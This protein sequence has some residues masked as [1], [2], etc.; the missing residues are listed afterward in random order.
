VYQFIGLSYEIRKFQSSDYFND[1][2]LFCW[3]L[4]DA[5]PLG[6]SEILITT[7]TLPILCLVV[8]L[9]RAFYLKESLDQT[10]T[11][12]ILVGGTL[13]YITSVSRLLLLG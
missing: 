12:R 11:P 4:S 3:S 13:G 8:S 9:V 6:L 1:K 7:V 2:F 10:R 5:S